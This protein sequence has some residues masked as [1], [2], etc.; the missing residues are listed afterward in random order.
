LCVPLWS[1]L[2]H[3]SG[4]SSATSPSCLSFPLS[5]RGDTGHPISKKTHPCIGAAAGACEG[6]RVPPAGLTDRSAGGG[7]SE[8][9]KG[10]RLCPRLRAA[11]T[12]EREAPTGGT[13]RDSAKGRGQGQRVSSCCRTMS[14]TLVSASTR[15]RWPLPQLR[16]AQRPRGWALSLKTSRTGAS[17]SPPSWMKVT[18]EHL[19][20]VVDWVQRTSPQT[21]RM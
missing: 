17:P 13:V 10:K 19:W 14:F 20:V 15:S 12:Q 18:A 11:A 7:R 16:A 5:P 6:E 3:A 1:P 21:Q 8:R 9:R 2:P 4:Q